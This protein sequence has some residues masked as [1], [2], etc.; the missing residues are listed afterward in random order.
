[1]AGT[2]LTG[3][4][5]LV[6]PA[7]TDLLYVVDDP[8]GTPLSRKATVANVLAAAGGAP[9]S[10]TQV[11]F[12]DGGALE[13]DSGFTFNKT[14]RRIVVGDG[15]NSQPQW[16]LHGSNGHA[17]LFTAS[18]SS[19]VVFDDALPIRF[20]IQP[21]ADV[22]SLSNFT[23]LLSLTEDS[24]NSENI[25]I[26]GIESTSSG[27]RAA[28]FGATPA[29]GT[30]ISPDSVYLRPGIATGT[31]TTGN[32]ILQTAEAIGSGS[33]AQTAIDALSVTPTGVVIDNYSA[34]VTPFTVNANALQ[35]GN[36]S[37][38]YDATPALRATITEAGE[39]SNTGGQS[40]SEIFGDGASVSAADATVFGNAASGAT[41]SVVVGVRATDGAFGSCVVLGRDAL[42]TGTR[43]V[44][45]GNLATCGAFSV[46][47]GPE[48]TG[49][50][51]FCTSIGQAAD[52][53]GFDHCLV[54]GR[55]STATANNQL[56]AGSTNSPLS[57]GY[58][59]NGVTNAT[60]QA[61]AL[62]GTGGSGT[63][64]GGASFTLSGGAGTGS[65]A[66][67]ATIFTYA[68]AGGSGSTLN[69]HAAVFSVGEASASYARVTRAGNFSC[70]QGQTNSEAFGSGAT[71]SS[72][73]AS[74]FGQGST[75]SN[76]G[77]T[78]LGKGSTCSGA[79]S[80]AV[81][82]SVSV[83]SA[84][85]VGVGQGITVSASSAFAIGQ[86]ASATGT[87]AMAF[88]TNC[89]AAHD[90]AICL[91]TGASSTATRQFVVGGITGGL[92]YVTTGYFGSGVVDATPQ[93][94]ALNATGGSGTDIAGASLTLAGG[95]P[96]GSG[97]GGDVIISTAPAGAS[98]TTLRSLSTRVHVKSTGRVGIAQSSPTG[99]LH[100]NH[101]VSDGAIPTLHLEQD[102]VSEEFIRF[103]GQAADTGGTE[104]TQSLVD[105][106]EVGG[107]TVEGYIRINVV[108]EN[109]VISDGAYYIPFYSLS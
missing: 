87:G 51:D 96:T 98:G 104:L 102:D 61:F 106:A 107:S 17:M 23:P 50:G 21:T 37:E 5:E 63:N 20:G 81:G 60:P 33:T 18:T 103:T 36:L 46:G 56:V 24:G 92:R 64:V 100:V 109:N 16:T 58:L 44:S 68:A 69:T 25:V 95:R 9:G 101:A 3:L 72:G 26:G 55:Q 65:A 59:G 10:D 85:S 34:T 70:T 79:L 93:S 76:N 19:G 7:S 86:N 40:G 35:S 74:A 31:G 49:A 1:M 52:N 108:D 47:I 80:T 78:A 73:N 54:L 57:A 90:S 45:I 53:G 83:T 67:G 105:A 42:V 77:T 32:A 22:G 11:I 41:R 14:N 97:L 91:G 12:N 48:V 43:S 62:R 27:F 28:V 30:N 75:A 99:L 29:S 6:A 38:W 88:G 71:V 66:G 2:K 8:G 84:N 13:A 89:A 82:D 39:F 94:F 4:N 15:T